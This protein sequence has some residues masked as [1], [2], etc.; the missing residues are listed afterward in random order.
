MRKERWQRRVWRFVP[1]F[2]WMLVITA[3]STAFF[4][5]VQTGNLLMPILHWLLPDASPVS[6][7]LV[8]HYV[9]KTAHLLEFGMLAILWYRA[10]TVGG[11]AWTARVAATVLAV[12]VSVAVLDELHQTLV[13][14]RTASARDVGWDSLGA[15][16]ALGARRALL[17][18]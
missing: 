10:L 12:S 3:F 18:S 17:R 13:P 2:M 15:A 16:L 7:G 6:L 11:R 9:R 5:S 4:S 14:G 1:A 8:H